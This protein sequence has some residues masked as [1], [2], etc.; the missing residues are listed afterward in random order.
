MDLT[1][2]IIP[3]LFISGGLNSIINNNNDVKFSGSFILN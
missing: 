2:N 1:E 3:Y